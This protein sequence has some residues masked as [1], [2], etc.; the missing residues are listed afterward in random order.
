M[1]KP[2]CILCIG[3][4]ACTCMSPSYQPLPQATTQGLAWMKYDSVSLYAKAITD[5][6]QPEQQ[7]YVPHATNA[8]PYKQGGGGAFNWAAQMLNIIA[9]ACK[10]FLISLFA[11]QYVQKCMQYY[12]L[13][14]ICDVTPRDVPHQMWEAQIRNMGSPDI[15]TWA[16]HTLPQSLWSFP[17]YMGTSAKSITHRTHYVLGPVRPYGSGKRVD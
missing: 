15:H 2:Q 10:G 5:Y 16:S 4:Q 12:H 9:K 8:S 7:A 1:L 11:A 6:I 14:G 17:P 13:F 3:T